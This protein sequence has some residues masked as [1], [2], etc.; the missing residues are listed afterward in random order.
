MQ[1]RREGKQLQ[2]QQRGIGR[3]EEGLR[4]KRGRCSR[5]QS[6]KEKKGVGK[7]RRRRRRRRHCDS[8]VRKPFA[9]RGERE[10]ELPSAPPEMMGCRQS[11]GVTSARGGGGGG[12]WRRTRNPL[13]AAAVAIAAGGGG[14]QFPPP[15]PPFGFHASRLLLRRHFFKRRWRSSWGNREGKK[16]PCM[17]LRTRPFL[18]PLRLFSSAARRSFVRSFARELMVFARHFHCSRGRRRRKG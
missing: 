11:G 17:R 3:G 5:S 7:G 18:P 2:D 8:S 4:G 12:F 9:E 1:G 10:G 6:A 14:K 15:D 13:V 16:F